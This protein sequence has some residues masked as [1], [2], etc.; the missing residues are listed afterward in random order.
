MNKRAPVQPY[1][2]NQIKRQRFLGLACPNTRCSA[3]TEPH[4][5]RD[6]Y[7]SQGTNWGGGQKGNVIIRKAFILQE[8]MILQSS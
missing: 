1:E 6:N 4:K 8:S 2:K 7:T 5:T 3:F